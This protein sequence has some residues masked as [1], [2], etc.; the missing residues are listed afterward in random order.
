M[1]RGDERL[2]V[3][4][5]PQPYPVKWPELP[6]P[7]RVVERRPGL[8]PAA[9]DGVPGRPA[10]RPARGGPHLLYFWATWCGPCKAAL[11]ELLAFESERKT[12]VIA[13]TDE[14]GETL[15][16]FFAAV[17]QAVSGARGHRRAAPVL[18][19]LRRERHAD[20]RARGRGGRHPVVLGRLL[21]G[22]GSRY[23]G[24]ALEWL[25]AGH[26]ALGAVKVH[27]GRPEE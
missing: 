25:G 9:A 24:L 18:P 7:P 15:D 23:R 14:P 3:T 13:I 16:G 21:A 4:I 11:P 10:A 27:T 2:E 8:E 12:P 19:G 17:R 22:E 26:R 1:L 5:V 6:G 20:V